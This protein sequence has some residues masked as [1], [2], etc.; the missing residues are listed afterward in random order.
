MTWWKVRQCPLAIARTG[1]P[2]GVT[3]AVL[4]APL[5]RRNAPKSTVHTYSPINVNRA[6]RAPQISQPCTPRAPY[7]KSQRAYVRTGHAVLI[8]VPDMAHDTDVSI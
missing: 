2:L 4:I 6:H 3:H 5:S 7:P 1:C 8:G